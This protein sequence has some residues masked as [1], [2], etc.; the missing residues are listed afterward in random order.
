MGVPESHVSQELKSGTLTVRDVV[1]FYFEFQGLRLCNY[2]SN[3]HQVK[4]TAQTIIDIIDDITFT[5]SS[6][7]YNSLINTLPTG[8]LDCSG[9]LQAQRLTSVMLH[10][11][12][13]PGNPDRAQIIE[14]VF[15]L[16]SCSCC[17]FGDDHQ[18]GL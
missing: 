10:A 9:L 18:V 8:V 11:L 6:I 7:K 15:S 14:P 17:K 16:A 1:K 4:A 12:K 3:E 2:G 13:Q 5:F